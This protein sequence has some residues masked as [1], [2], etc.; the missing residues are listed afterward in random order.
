[1]KPFLISTY[2][3]CMFLSSWCQANF[4]TQATFESG[5]FLDKQ[6][7]RTECL[8]K[9]TQSKQETFQNF[10]YISDA[11]DDTLIMS[12]NK[13]EEF[14]IYGQAK[15]RWESVEVDISSSHPKYMSTQYDPEFQEKNILLSVLIEGS[16]SLYMYAEPK[17]NRFF[18]KK[19]EMEIKE[20]IFKNYL[21]SDNQIGTNVSYKQQL[22][23]YFFCET[24]NFDKLESVKYQKNELLRFF[25]DY[26]ACT[27]EEFIDHC[28]ELGK[29]RFHISIRSGI[30]LNS[31]VFTKLY[32]YKTLRTLGIRHRG[33]VRLGIEAEYILPF[34]KDR[35][36]MVIEPTL[37]S[38]RGLLKNELFFS[39]DQRDAEINLSSFQASGGLRYSLTPKNNLNFFLGVNAVKDFP[40]NS[41]VGSQIEGENP[42]RKSQQLFSFNLGCLLRNNFGVELRYW[43]SPYQLGTNSTETLSFQKLSFILGY[44]LF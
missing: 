15:Y 7:V 39:T 2:L 11:S 40:F 8:I 5:Y 31:F 4:L 43:W 44:R 16:M 14:G 27:G 29:S 32:P 33:G 30:S 23:H 3:L 12:I 21:N 42:I 35:W 38:Y 24:L 41:H 10:F 22:Y 26:Y 13:V 6:G 1:M 19:G 17:G 18:F 34:N 25:R 37:Q 9:N 36:S 20:L 28:T